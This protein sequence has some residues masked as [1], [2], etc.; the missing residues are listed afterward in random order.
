MSE[1]PVQCARGEDCHPG[2]PPG[3]THSHGWI[4]QHCEDRMRANLETI[5]NQWDPL[6]LAVTA[7]A[8]VRGE[9]G[10]QKRGGKTHGLKVSHDAIEARRRATDLVW[11]LIRDL[12]DRYDE[13][14]RVLP[15]PDDQGTDSLARWLSKWHVLSFTS[16]PSRE[17][18]LEVWHE[19]DDVVR[20]VWYA[21]NA[22]PA[23]ID[24]GVPCEEHGTN[25]RGQRVPC[26][27][28]LIAAQKGDTL[29]GLRCDKDPSHHVTV[30]EWMHSSWRKR[31]TRDLD[32][33]GVRN[34][35]RGIGKRHTS[36]SA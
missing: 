33:D 8:A 3:L 15:I 11:F 1:Y 30:A 32:P 7:A 29:P 36:E 4:C 24:T 20:H 5:A 26:A 31:N 6:A 28:T 14:Q 19:T 18:C 17:L 9:Q 27:G 34:L 16:H 22:K 12:L 21:V 2:N 10:K 25:D 13:Q 23:R 35:L